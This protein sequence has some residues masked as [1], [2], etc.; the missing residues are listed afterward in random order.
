MVRPGG[1]LNHLQ[2]G[3][4][5][6]GAG[7]RLG[8]VADAAAQRHLSRGAGEGDGGQQ[9]QEGIQALRQ[10]AA[11]EVRAG[12]LLRRWLL[13]LPR[14]IYNVR[15]RLPQPGRDQPGIL[16]RVIAIGI[17]GDQ[18]AMQFLVRFED[19]VHLL[20]KRFH[21]RITW[22]QVVKR[23][24]DNGHEANFFLDVEI[25]V[26]VALEQFL[27]P[28]RN[29][30]FRFPGLRIFVG[31]RKVELLFNGFTDLITDDWK[32]GMGRVDFQN[33][34]LGRRCRVKGCLLL[35]GQAESIPPLG[36]TSS[37]I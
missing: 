36:F 27:N 23:I 6:A 24:K 12:P 22:I 25:P 11:L 9:G 3:A 8:G 17:V 20:P 13:L 10:A 29:R 32:H 21:P 1:G 33:F 34:G 35:R 4:A 37:R 14:R 15:K 2:G 19:G 16:L 30:D 7:A 31:R 18:V 5:D 26:F 28:V